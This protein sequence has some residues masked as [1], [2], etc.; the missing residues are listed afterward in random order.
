MFK[1]I[2][3]INI[4]KINND[5]SKFLKKEFSK[6]YIFKLNKFLSKE[7]LI[8]TVY[9]NKKNIFRA[10]NLTSF[11]ETKVVIIGQDPYHNN[12]QANGLS[13][14][15]NDREKIPPSLRNIFKELSDNYPHKNEFDSSL[16]SW[17]QQGVLLLNS[18][19]TV[20]EKKAGSHQNMGWEELTSFIIKS[21]SDNKSNI[22]FLLWGKHALDKQSL[23][24]E[25]KHHILKAPHPSPLSAYR[26]FFGCKHFLKVNDILKNLNHK[27]IKW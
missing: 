7:D 14:A 18:V 17:A 27:Q 24:N 12:G 2:M 5:W 8:T 19:L 21:L 25:K 6:K 15:V 20:R 9:P 13:F 11:S 16:E 4:N 23:I 22:I 1:S 10:L 26:G 3:I